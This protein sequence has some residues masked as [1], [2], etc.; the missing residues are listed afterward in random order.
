MPAEV[1]RKGTSPGHRDTRLGLDEL[2]VRCESEVL[3]EV[4]AVLTRVAEQDRQNA[5]EALLQLNAG[6]YGFCLECHAPIP[7][8]RLDA[9]CF[10]VRCADCDHDRERCA[11]DAPA[12]L[13][14]V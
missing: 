9:L 12:H 5:E 1:G 3:D 6:T 11:T 14:A 2:R 4:C 13:Y 7:A 8:A 10:A